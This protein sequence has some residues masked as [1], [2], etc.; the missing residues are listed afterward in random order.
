M[1]IGVMIAELQSIQAA[2]GDVDVYLQGPLPEVGGKSRLA[3]KAAGF[4]A[5]TEEVSAFDSFFIVPEEYSKEDGGW[6]VN[7]RTWPY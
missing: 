5:P 3:P 4:H 1:K 2:Q 7:I 6:A